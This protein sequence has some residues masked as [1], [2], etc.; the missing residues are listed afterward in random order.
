MGRADIDALAYGCGLLHDPVD[1]GGVH[2]G[3]VHGGTVDIVESHDLE[4]HKASLRL[5]LLLENYW[6]D[7]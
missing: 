1:G 5:I 2:D 3:A 4:A 7:G 6:E